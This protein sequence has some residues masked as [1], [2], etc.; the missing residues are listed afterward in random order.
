MEMAADYASGALHPGDY[1]LLPECHAA[2]QWQHIGGDVHSVK[3]RLDNV[4]SFTNR[5]H[6][7]LQFFS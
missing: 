5:L 7:C 1:R 4:V 6:T 3:P 2:A